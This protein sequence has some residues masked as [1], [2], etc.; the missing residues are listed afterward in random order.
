M[1]VV[2]EFGHVVAAFACGE[3]VRRVVLH[4]LALS[5]TDVSLDRRPWAVI[6]GGPVLGVALPLAW[7]AAMKLHRS[8]LS[9]MVQFFAGFCLVANGAYL[10]AGALAGVGDAGDL[11]RFEAPTWPA[12]L[13][14]LV[15][16]A[17]GLRLWNGLG[18]SM[19][20]AIR[21]NP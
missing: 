6:W 11:I 3:T 15:A 19:G 14:G 16:T 10:G 1:Q 17:L 13:F 5:R 20:S 9:Y 7:L 4:P 21:R 2:H 8:R 18:A 12:I